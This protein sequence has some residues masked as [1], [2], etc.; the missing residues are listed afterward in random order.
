[1]KFEFLPING[2]MM[3]MPLIGKSSDLIFISF[4]ENSSLMPH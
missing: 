1:M 2:M 3:M 4:F